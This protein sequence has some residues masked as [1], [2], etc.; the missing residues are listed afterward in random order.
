MHVNRDGLHSLETPDSFETAGGF[1]VRLINHGGA[2]HVHLHLDDALSDVAALEATNHYV[3]EGADRLVRIDA[4]E[5]AVGRGNLKVVTGYGARTRYVDVRLVEP[6]ETG[7]RVRVDASLARPQPR[8]AA[9]D[10][11]D[12]LRDEATVVLLGGLALL[13]ASAV[14]VLVPTTPVRLGAVA[15][16]VAVVGALYL[17]R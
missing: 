2:V 1:D 9:D 8:E 10:P 6:E 5:G 4:E 3:R 17:V 12:G 16:A 15:V 14:A 11:D 13:A 7:D